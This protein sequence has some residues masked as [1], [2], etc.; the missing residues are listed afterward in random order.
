MSN[1]TRTLINKASKTANVFTKKRT[2]GVSLLLLLLIVT[3]YIGQMTAFPNSDEIVIN[4]DYSFWKAFGIIVGK[5]GSTYHAVSGDTGE[6]MSSGSNDDPVIQYAI[7]TLSA[8]GGGSVGIRAAA[9]SASVVLKNGV[10]LV[11]EKGATGIT[12][13]VYAGATCLIDDYNAGRIRYYSSGTLVFDE[14]MSVSSLTVSGAAIANSFNASTYYVGGVNVTGNMLTGGSSW[15]GSWNSTVAQI[16]TNSAIAWGKITNANTTVHQLITLYQN[17]NWQSAWNS[18]VSNIIFNA[19]IIWSH[20]SNANSTVNQLIAASTIAWS[21]ILNANS[22]VHQLII[23]YQNF[24]WQSTWNATVQQLASSLTH[25]YASSW[26]NSTKFYLSGSWLGFIEPYTFIIDK[27]GSYSRA[28][29]GANSTLAFQSTNA[30]TIFNAVS[31]GNDIFVKA[32]FYNFTNPVH[33]SN[34]TNW[35][36]EGYDTW[37]YL[38]ENRPNSNDNYWHQWCIFDTLDNTVVEN[39]TIQNMRFDGNY[40]NNNLFGSVTH[41]VACIWLA[42]ARHVTVQNCWIVN[43]RMFGLD[44]AAYGRNSYD[45]HILRSVFENNQWNQIELNAGDHTI[46]G[47]SIEYNYCSGSCGD[48]SINT[49]GYGSAVA[50]NIRIVG[51]TIDGMTG[52]QGSSGDP[53]YGIK[54]E[55]SGDCIVSNNIIRGCS[56]PI[57]D[58]SFG[59]GNHTISE[60]YI[61]MV[62]SANTQFGIYVVKNNTVVTGNHVWSPPTNDTECIYFREGY[63]NR[64]ASDNVIIQVGTGSTDGIKFRGRGDQIIGNYLVGIADNKIKIGVDATLFTIR[65]NTGYNPIGYEATP[66]WG[67][68]HII[69]DPDRG[70]NAT[71]VSAVT[72]TNVGSAKNLYISGGTVTVITVDGVT[73]YTATGVYVHLEPLDT[74]SITFSSAPTIKVIGE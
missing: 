3:F 6:S 67:S 34:N 46:Y 18:T 28:W 52:T 37:L 13:S 29:Y 72:Y 23:Q 71:W 16:I 57:A 11:I 2:I 45:N 73:L 8:A 40:L 4:P 15:Q 51:N 26:V 60:N 22:T 41:G 59:D 54:L 63:G 33:V 68:T 50:R 14:N 1:I 64:I 61:Y 56:Q 48:I 35:F 25:L 69:V 74:F 55:C 44:F 42:G 12:V 31:S 38:A 5:V 65:D 21:H 39:V 9:Y 66:I 24:A 47:C 58:D 62:D 7:D 30:S 32:G 53:H 20:I 49:Y 27:S 43:H 70:S 10:R 19:A 36:G 17:F